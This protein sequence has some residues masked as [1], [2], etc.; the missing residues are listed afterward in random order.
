MVSAEMTR[1]RWWRVAAIV[2]DDV[3]ELVS[4][5]L[6]GYG[7]MAVEEQELADRIR[8]VTG[9]PEEAAAR[10]A[11]GAIA[12]LVDEL[13]V[14]P[15]SDDGLDAWREHARPVF[16]NRFVIAPP[17]RPDPGDSSRIRLDIDPE[18][19]FGSG[20]H[21]STR[22]CL[23][24]LADLDLTGSTVMDVGTGSGVLAIAALQLGA[25]AA[26][27]IDI[28]PASPAVAAG[29]ARRNGV[30]DR[31]TAS[32]AGIDETATAAGPFDLVVANLL[33]PVIRDLTAPLAGAVAPHGRLIL[34]GL[35]EEQTDEII[36]RFGP[37]GFRVAHRVLEL[38]WTALLLESTGSTPVPS[39]GGP[40]PVDRDHLHRGRSRTAASDH[41]GDDLDRHRLDQPRPRGRR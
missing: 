8:V 35:L 26:H 16:T 41:A 2:S 36:G 12:D 11:A 29:N 7:A 14:E 20:S 38:G 28:D 23:D 15:I 27:A 24:L 21:P 19:S 10:R 25:S 18:R 40:H 9:F 1:N 37:H 39:S 34:A 5:R 6:M 33:A 31:L 17:W 30:D 22:L 4:D 3:H 13:L 32:T